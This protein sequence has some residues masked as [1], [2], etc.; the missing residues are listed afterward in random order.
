MK[1]REVVYE[2]LSYFTLSLSSAELVPLREHYNAFPTCTWGRFSNGGSLASRIYRTSRIAHIHNAPM[3]AP[4]EGFSIQDIVFTQDLCCQTNTEFDE[5]WLDGDAWI[6]WNESRSASAPENS[7]L[8]HSS[9]SINTSIDGE[10]TWATHYR[11]HVLPAEP[12]R[13]CH[14]NHPKAVAYLKSMQQELKIEGDAMN[15]P[16][17]HSQLQPSLRDKHWCLPDSPEVMK[18]SNMLEEFTS[19]AGR[20]QL[21][22]IDVEYGSLEDQVSA[23]LQVCVEA[24]KEDAGLDKK[25][26]LLIEAY[27]R[28]N[29]WWR[30]C[31]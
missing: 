21:L 2:H 4:F 31:A 17:L 10:E 11:C 14:F 25:E 15:E 8:H 1:M 6:H 5:E 24:Y 13:L 7:N 12:S 27:V 23:M 30:Y 19:S 18:H 9:D 29:V 16:V 20:D 28:E 26:D 22:R 3:P